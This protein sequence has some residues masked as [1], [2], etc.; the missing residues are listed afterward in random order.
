M[1]LIPALLLLAAAQL[2]AQTA[3]QP[4]V[5]DPAVAQQHRLPHPDPGMPPIAAAAHVY[6]DVLTQ[7]CVDPSGHV[8]WAHIISGKPMLQG[9]ALDYI[10][11]LSFTPFTQNDQPVYATFVITN[12]FGPHTP[13]A[14][15]TN[16]VQVPA[17][18]EPVQLWMALHEC[19]QAQTE[20]SKP[21]Q[22][23]KHC[24]G[25]VK[26]ADDTKGD[27][28]QSARI[29]AYLEASNAFL[30]NHQFDDALAAANKAVALTTPGHTDNGTL[31]LAYA[32]RALAENS[33]K[34]LPAADADLTQ[35]EQAERAAIAI[36]QDKA[37]AQAYTTGLK[38]LLTLHADVLKAM[39]N[40]QAAAAKTSEAAT[41]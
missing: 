33:L 3:L 16:H 30:M 17:A 15:K 11:E 5:I 39:G 19:D 38:N 41:P 20:K 18:Q 27:T 34:N 8:T 13:L 1:R 2:H 9:A 24:K 28:F 23:V 21:E 31:A 36:V 12:S 26:A 10:H 4:I 32:G 37:H 7:V 40:T 22:V 35:A 29:K 14:S 6:G 25:L